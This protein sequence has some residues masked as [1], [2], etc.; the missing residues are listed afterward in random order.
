MT[1]PEKLFNDADEFFSEMHQAIARAQSSVYL[2]TYIFDQDKL[3]YR[4]LAVL[5]QAAERGIKVHLLIDGVGSAH[6]TFNDA[7]VYRKQGIDF[8]FFSNIC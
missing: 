6:W 1:G 2:E 8:Q 7:E 4:T 3:G 5:A